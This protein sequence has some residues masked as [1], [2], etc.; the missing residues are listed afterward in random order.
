MGKPLFMQH[1][2]ITLDDGTGEQSFECDV[3]AATVEAEPGDV[4]TY[5]TLCPDGTYSQAAADTFVFH[6]I[7]AQR[8]S[9]GAAPAT[10]G[11]G[12][13]RYLD[14]HAGTDL[15]ELTCVYNA[16][17]DAVPSPEFPAKRFTCIAQ[18][19]AYGG[20]RDTWAEFDVSMPITGNPETLT[21]APV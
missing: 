14:D 20:E 3:H 13:A 15:S 19:P 7:G 21:A 10:D 9:D 17:G 5:V 8:W 4:V 18:H 1:V 12:L 2:S 6:V 11:M 16:H